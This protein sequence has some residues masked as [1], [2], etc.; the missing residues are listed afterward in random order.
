VLFGCEQEEGYT[1]VIGEVHKDPRALTPIVWPHCVCVGAQQPD[2][3]V[4]PDGAVYIAYH[5]WVDRWGK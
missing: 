3:L 2:D 1:G 4:H 5:C